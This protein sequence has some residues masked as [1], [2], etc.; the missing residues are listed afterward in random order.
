MTRITRG[1]RERSKHAG[2][3]PI[4]IGRLPT[5]RIRIRTY[6]ARRK[7]ENGAKSYSDCCAFV[8]AERHNNN[9]YRLKAEIIKKKSQTQN[10]FKTFSSMHGLN[11]FTHIYVYIKYRRRLCKINS[12]FRPGRHLKGRE[13]R[14]YEAP[15]YKKIRTV[16]A[17]P[18]RDVTT[19]SL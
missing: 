4:S 3:I 17:T 12:P 7:T 14:D 8:G 10:E 2:K 6:R 9:Y 19:V 15:P 16:S 5:D 18:H 1:C 13:R 11:A